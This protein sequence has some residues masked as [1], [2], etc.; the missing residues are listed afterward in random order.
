MDL[1]LVKKGGELIR[2]EISQRLRAALEDLLRLFPQTRLTLAFV[3]G[4][5]CISL[6]TAQRAPSGSST[7]P[8]SRL[9]LDAKKN[10]GQEAIPPARK[11]IAGL[12]EREGEIRSRKSGSSH[13]EPTATAGT[14]FSHRVGMRFNKNRGPW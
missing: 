8:W 1:E 13:Q 14:V 4:H 10:H 2:R 7:A 5:R 11:R 12:P 6:N 9:I 3:L